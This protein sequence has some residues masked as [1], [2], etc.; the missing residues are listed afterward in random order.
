MEHQDWNTVVWNKPVKKR[1][2]KAERVAREKPSGTKQFI[3]LDGDNPDA[4]KKVDY[5]LRMNI[6]KARQ[7]KK[8]TQKELAGKINVQANIVNDYESGKTVPSS[9]ILAKM[10]RVLGTKLVR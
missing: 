4:P 9:A 2:T 6:Q 7:A 1:E 3:N 10:A 5:D 8:M